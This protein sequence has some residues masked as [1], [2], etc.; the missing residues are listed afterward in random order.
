[1]TDLAD[2]LLPLM[3]T[4]WPEF[5]REGTVALSVSRQGEEVIA[6]LVN[7]ASNEVLVELLQLDR[8]LFD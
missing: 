6:A 7:E 4:A 2:L 1:L 3:R 8:H 5:W